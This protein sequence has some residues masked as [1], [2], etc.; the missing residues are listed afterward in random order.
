VDGP[1]CVFVNSTSSTFSGPEPASWRSFSSIFPS[2]I[3]LSGLR[4]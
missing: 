3:L 2:R 1:V 4:G